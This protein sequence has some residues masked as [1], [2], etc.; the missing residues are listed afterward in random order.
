MKRLVSPLVIILALA[1]CVGMPSEVANRPIEKLRLTDIKEIAGA[2][3][4]CRQINGNRDTPNMVKLREEIGRRGGL[5][6]AEWMYVLQQQPAIGMSD[7]GV[8][9]A[10]G[11]PHATLPP[12][13]GSDG[14]PRFAYRYYRGAGR[15]LTVWFQEWKVESVD[16]AYVGKLN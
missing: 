14:I 15:D 1:S 10:L 8:L 12:T 16:G 7:I 13:T 11:N 4:S 3:G 6:A 5:S 9:A 2:Y